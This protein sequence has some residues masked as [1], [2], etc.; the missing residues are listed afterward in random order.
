MSTPKLPN[1]DNSHTEKDKKIPFYRM[2]GFWLIVLAILIFIIFIQHNPFANHK[3]KK[4]PAVPVVTAPTRKG[5]VAVYLTELGGVVPVY[6]VTVKPQI[7]GQL[8][9]VLFKEGQMVKKGDLLAEVDPRIYQAQLL[10]YEGQLQRDQATLANDQVNLKRY[11]V[12]WRQNSIAKQT[13]DNQVA[14][15]NQDQGTVKLDEGLVQ[16][17]KVNLT[18]CEITSPVDGRIGLRLVDPGNLVQISDTTGIAVVDTLSPIDVIFSIPEDNIPDVLNEIEGGK[19]LEV[20]AYDRQQNKVLA[21][22][23]LLTIDNQI[24]P[25]TG[26]V[27]MKA[28]FQNAEQTLFPNQFVNVQLLVKTLQGAVIVPTAA[29]QHGPQNSTF[30]YVLNDDKTVSVKP[31]VVGE[32]SGE[33]TVIQSGVTDGQTVVVEGTDKLTDGAS[34]TLFDPNHP[35]LVD[36]TSKKHRHGSA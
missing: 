6:S 15:V 9:K 14:L 21:V 26:T 33:D 2:N 5:D 27:K 28:Q 10:Q 25:T 17:V 3:H 35:A 32:V 19:T 11:Q 7:T 23:S 1:S 31:V 16:G 30:V 4:P 12:L 13:L 20:K 36:D 18:Y 22:G 24:D 34:V 8:W 29:I